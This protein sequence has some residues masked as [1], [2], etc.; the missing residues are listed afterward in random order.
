MEMDNPRQL[1][2]LCQTI[3]PLT[4]H[5]QE[6]LCSLWCTTVLSQLESNDPGLTRTFRGIIACEQ[7]VRT[8]SSE[9]RDGPLIVVRR[10]QTEIMISLFI[11]YTHL[12]IVFPQLVSECLPTKTL[13]Q[14]LVLRGAVNFCMQMF[15]SI[16]RIGIFDFN[17]A[18]F[19]APLPYLMPVPPVLF[20]ERLR[21]SWDCF[22][23]VFFCARSHNFDRL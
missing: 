14:S 23:N 17:F 6:I 21:E 10:G 5:S 15:L 18:H 22:G 19:L 3:G 1:C 13:D 16:G 9:V 20:C 7:W 12:A 4:L 11:S 8:T 2:Q